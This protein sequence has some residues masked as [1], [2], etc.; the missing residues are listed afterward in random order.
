MV[1]SRNS[2]TSA[3]NCRA[4]NRRSTRL[5][6]VDGEWPFP[7]AKYSTWLSTFTT[8]R[9]LRKV[10]SRSTRLM[11]A[12]KAWASRTFMCPSC[13]QRRV[14]HQAF[15]TMLQRN[16]DVSTTVVPLGQKP[17]QVFSFLSRDA[18]IFDLNDF[19]CHLL[20][21]HRIL[22]AALRKLLLNSCFS[23]H[24]MDIND[25]DIQPQGRCRA[26][27]ILCAHPF[28][29]YCASSSVGGTVDSP[30]PWCSQESALRSSKIPL[31]IVSTAVHFERLPLFCSQVHGVHN[32]DP[33]LRGLPNGFFL[34]P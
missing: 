24:S 26:V 33:L 2:A 13:F 12:K 25:M 3:A 6:S 28:S 5:S 31:L 27:G 34:R 9:Q 21:E 15:A 32:Q 30:S 20:P 16:A 8:S 1:H 10:G 11:W 4:I 7:T 23:S 22:T 29:R 19:L 14:R 18:P 17:R